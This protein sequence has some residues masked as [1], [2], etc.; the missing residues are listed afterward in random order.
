[1][2]SSVRLKIRSI[3]FYQNYQAKSRKS[4]AVYTWKIRIHQVIAYEELFFCTIDGANVY[5]NANETPSRTPLD[6]QRWV[7]VLRFV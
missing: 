2:M 3:I 1:M 5:G 4:L 6:G 7:M